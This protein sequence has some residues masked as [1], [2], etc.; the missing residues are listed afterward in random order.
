MSTVYLGLGSNVDARRNIRI[1]IEWL[2][3]HFI[4]AAFSPVYQSPAVGFDG[5][6]FL[7]LVARVETRADP[8]SLKQLLN[9]FEDS[10]GRNRDA[11]KF[12]DRTVDIDILL[13]DELV[14]SDPDLEIPRA[15]ITRFA[16]VLKPLAD[17]AA[18]LLYPGSEQTIAD[19]WAD[20]PKNDLELKQ[21]D[22]G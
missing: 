15:E 21:I 3:E 11:P 10:H 6:D 12:S 5:E 9:E 1:A 19:L 2:Q 17:I 13:Y 7:N 16:H 20:F 14:I 8:L 22:L 18:D 4:D